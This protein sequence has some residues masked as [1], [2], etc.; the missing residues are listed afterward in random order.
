MK[1]MKVNELFVHRYL[2]EHHV[3][4]VS[5]YF[6]QTGASKVIRVNPSQGYRITSLSLQ[7]MAGY[8]AIE[9]FT[10]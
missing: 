6:R 8:D 10:V 5:L 2:A 7:A 1:V 4:M 3:Y 9:F